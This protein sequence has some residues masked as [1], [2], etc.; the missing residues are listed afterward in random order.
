MH[1]GW[2]VGTCTSLTLAVLVGC[3]GDDPDVVGASQG[4][5]GAPGADAD[6]QDGAP[7]GADGGA[8]VSND[9]PDTPVDA[10][11]DDIPGNLVVN[12]SFED[13]TTGWE[14]NG[15]LTKRTDGP[16]HCSAFLQIDT[17][18][19]YGIAQRGVDLSPLAG[20]AGGQVMVEFGASFRSLEGA[21]DPV[22]LIVANY[23]DTEKQTVYSPFL[24][25]NGAWVTASGTIMLTPSASFY[26]RIQSE[27]IRKLGVDRVWV[28][29]KN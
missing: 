22:I 27:Q 19:S 14:S 2:R 6:T 20:D 11:C 5:G 8:D 13:G 12:G 28:A 17:I 25:T 15:V 9:A 29:R 1:L 24:K 10:G 16:A 4:D 18:Q 23:A 3:L 7:G 21:L 26:V